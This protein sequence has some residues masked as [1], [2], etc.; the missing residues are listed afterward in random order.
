LIVHAHGEMDARSHA[1]MLFPISRLMRAPWNI[2]RLRKWVFG[3]GLG[4]LLYPNVPRSIGRVS[5][6]C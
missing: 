1:K 4:R 6:T 5:L 3:R 2:L